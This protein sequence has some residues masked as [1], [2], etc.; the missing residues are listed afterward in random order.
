MMT[1]EQRSH[2]QSLCREI[3]LAQ[4]ENILIR[5]LCE[6]HEL[7]RQWL[8]EL[9]HPPDSQQ[10][11]RDGFKTKSKVNGNGHRSE[12]NPNT[13]ASNYETIVDDAL[14][15]MHSDCSSLQMLYPERGAGGELR[16][17]AFRGFSPQA[18]AFWKWVRADSKSTCGMALRTTQRVVAPDIATCDFMVDSEDRQ[19]Y[20]RTGIRACQTTPLIAPAGSVIGMISTHWRTR[21]YP[22]EKD[23][24]LFDVLA[25]EAADL[26]QHRG[27]KERQ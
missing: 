19:V 27:K 8:C 17:L 15:L 5:L 16:L 4:D 7:I 18:A 14:A 23:F 22:S 13:G 26:I 11:L 3:E 10:R 25:R 2:I 9:N 24:L 6:L 20:L 12:C 1:N 21:H